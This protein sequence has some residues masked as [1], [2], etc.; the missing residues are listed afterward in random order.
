MIR[1]VKWV[2]SEC[3]TTGSTQ[4]KTKNSAD[5]GWHK[6]V[7][8]QAW[9][10]LLTAEEVDS[11]A[12]TGDEKRK[13]KKGSKKRCACDRLASSGGPRSSTIRSVAR[14]AAYSLRFTRHG[15]AERA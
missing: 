13:G 6:T 1:S 12:A 4:Q 5:R 15:M 7:R 2:N 10:R 8:L 3:N 9:H 14:R 11:E